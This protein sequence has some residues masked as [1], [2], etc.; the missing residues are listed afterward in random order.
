MTKKKKEKFPFGI[1]FQEMILH[2]IISDKKLG[3]KVLNLIEDSYFEII[4]HQVIAYV[5]KRYYKKKKRV[6]SKTLFSEELRSLYSGREGVSSMVI[7]N[8][9]D[10]D[11]TQIQN[12]VERLYTTEV[13][14]SDEVLDRVVKFSR[15]ISL[16][17]EIEEADLLNFTSYD[18]LSKKIQKAINVGSNIDGNDGTFLVRGAKERAYHRDDDNKF[19]TPFRQMN[20]TLNGGGLNEGN[21]VVILAEAKRFKTG[22]LLNIALGYMRRKKKI[23]IFDLENGEKA[24]TTRSEQSLIKSTQEGITS[25]SMDSKLSKLLRKYKRLG[26]ELVIKRFPS[27]T[28]V[29]TMDAYL[30]ELHQ[31][32]GITFD[33]AIFDYGDLLGATTGR[34]EEDKKISDA[35]LDMKNFAERRKLEGVFT[36]SH[37]KREASKRKGTKY[38]ANDVAKSIE[39]IRHA[40]CIWGLQES[41]EEKEGGV[42]RIEV[43]DQRDGKLGNCL[44]W[45]DIAKQSV[46]EFSQSERKDYFEQ[47]GQEDQDEKPKKRERKT[48][49]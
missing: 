36:A 23:I 37:V 5:I 26:A 35:Y 30:D 11:K 2:L 10:H 7:E 8:L 46:K 14:D 18:K 17:S 27:G 47:I 28:T 43:I 6:P 29:D 42:M 24:L 19:P 32:Y 12:L 33:I 38:E 1:D 3:Y 4:P 39:K 13:N 20:N 34:V 48:D 44:L 22:I 31:K 16:K 41:D 45:V 9:L 49:L 15:Y 40:D 25:G 21:L